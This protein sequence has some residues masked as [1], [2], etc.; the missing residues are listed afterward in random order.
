MAGGHGMQQLMTQN[1]VSGVNATP[2]QFGAPLANAP[3]PR[4]TLPL[5][6]G[7]PTR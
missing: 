4:D 5:A 7:K 6:T 1:S 2:P 3:G